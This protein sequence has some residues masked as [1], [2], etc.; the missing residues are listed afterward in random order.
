MKVAEP[1][2]VLAED[3]NLQTRQRL[4]QAAG[5]IFAE[6]GFRVATVRDICNRAGANVAAINY[7]FGDKENL[8]AAVLRYAHGCSIQRHPPDLGIKTDSSPQHR[9]AAFVRSF[10]NRI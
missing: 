3:Q 6:Q 8:Y 9:L 5:E 2:K 7:H 10:M 4:L 1:P